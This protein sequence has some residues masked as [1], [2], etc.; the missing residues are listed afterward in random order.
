VNK[1]KVKIAATLLAMF[2]FGAVSGAG[3]SSF[4]HSYFFSPP[5]PE[6]LQKHL[7]GFWT[8]QLDLTP[9]QQ[10]QAKPIAA[11]FAQQADTLRQQSSSR[12]SQLADATDTRLSQYLTPEQK[13]KLQQM[14]RHRNEDFDHHGPPPDFLGGPPHGPPPGP[15][16]GP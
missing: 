3:L 8:R 7:V 5:H 13:V 9:E 6:G 12:F 11:D 2:L 10:E 4:W 14:I 15:P 1:P 16:P